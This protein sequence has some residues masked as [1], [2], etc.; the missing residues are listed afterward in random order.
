MLPWLGV[1]SSPT[2]GRSVPKPVQLDRFD[3]LAVR[4]GGYWQLAPRLADGL[5]GGSGERSWPVGPVARGALV[6]LC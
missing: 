4:D 3:G 6:V 5:N 2:W 1:M